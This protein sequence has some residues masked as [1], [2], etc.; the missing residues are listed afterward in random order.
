MGLNGMSVLLGKENILAKLND[1]EVS[2]ITG[3]C[4][5]YCKTMGW[6]GIVNSDQS[7]RIICEAYGDV[8]DRCPSY[9]DTTIREPIVP[10]REATFISPFSMKCNII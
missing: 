5:C 9:T 6:S 2:K 8:F 1:H 3:G 10:T 7:C 4:D